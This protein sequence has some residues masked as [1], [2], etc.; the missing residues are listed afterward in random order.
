MSNSLARWERLRLRQDRGVATRKLEALGDHETTGPFS[1]CIGWIFSPALERSD[2]RF[3][4][5]ANDAAARRPN[6]L[7]PRGGPRTAVAGHPVS[8][9]IEP[10]SG[11]NLVRRV[12]ALSR[13]SP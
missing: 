8:H 1:A 2:R 13:L 11:A 3:P 9:G 5:P 4:L 6:D 12:R 10:R 7:R